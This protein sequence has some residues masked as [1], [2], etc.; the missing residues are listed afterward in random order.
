MITCRV[1]W[2]QLGLSADDL[3]YSESQKKIERVVFP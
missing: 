3:A 2:W 1:E